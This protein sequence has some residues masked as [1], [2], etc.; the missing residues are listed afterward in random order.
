MS[1]DYISSFG[2][3]Y[4]VLETDDADLEELEDGLNEYIEN[5]LGDGFEHFETGS[6]YTGDSDGCFITIEEPF[7]NGLDLTKV[8]QKLDEEI[9]RLKLETVG[10]FNAVGGLYVF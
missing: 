8:K 6:A 3:G 9:K 2:I 10:D 7:K 1:V 5:E 4:Q